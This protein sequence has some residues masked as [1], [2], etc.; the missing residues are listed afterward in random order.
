MESFFSF[1]TMAYSFAGYITLMLS[2][3][4]EIHCFRFSVS[5]FPLKISCYSDEFS[6]LYVFSSHL[7]LS[8]TFCILSDLTVL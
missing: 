3:G 8:N 6:I 1:S 5:K 2:S 4:C 7:K